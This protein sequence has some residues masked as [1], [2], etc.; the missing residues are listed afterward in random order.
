MMIFQRREKGSETLK[1]NEIG[2]LSYQP[3]QQLRHE[4]AH[5]ANRDRQTDKHQHA[6]VGPEI[7]Q[8]GM[9]VGNY[10]FGGRRSG[11]SHLAGNFQR[12]PRRFKAG[13]F[14]RDGRSV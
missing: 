3:K 6:R 1:E 11:R 10:W 13:S 8:H 12:V 5:H 2:N 4:R 7:P 9:P 14:D